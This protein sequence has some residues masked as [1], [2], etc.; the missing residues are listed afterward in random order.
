M[1]I[2]TVN[3]EMA[4]GAILI[5]PTGQIVRWS[6]DGSLFTDRFSWC[7]GMAFQ[8]QELH[9]WPRQH[10]RI[11]RAMWRVAG[12]T[13]FLFDRRMFIDKRPLFVGMAFQTSRV[14]RGRI[15]QRLGQEAAV[16]VMTVGTFHAA[17]RHF[18]M[19]GFREIRALI[20]VTLIAEIRLGVPQQKLRPFRRVRRMTV[21]TGNPMPRMFAAPK[22]E[23]L[24]VVALRAFMAFQTHRRSG[25]SGK[26]AIRNHLRGFGLFDIVVK[27]LSFGILAF[28][29]ELLGRAIKLDVLFR[30]AV[31]GFA[32]ALVNAIFVVVGFVMRRQRVVRRLIRM[33]FRTSIA[34]DILTGIRRWRRRS[35]ALRKGFAARGKKR[36]RRR[37][38]AK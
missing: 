25:G 34:A 19:E 18:V 13:A 5:A 31:A 12:L 15:A 11:R 35:L 22:I 38:R 20:G 3:I 9:L 32:A 2:G 37:C 21:K 17:F 33:A 36:H 26:T 27:C 29:D 30:A 1:P 8:T 23:A 14:A 7:I 16:L 24:F 4:S 6:R 28:F 10:L